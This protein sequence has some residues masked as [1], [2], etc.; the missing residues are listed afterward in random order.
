M[1][2]SSKSKPKHSIGRD[3]KLIGTGVAKELVLVGLY[4]IQELTGADLHYK[5]RKG[6]QP[7]EKRWGER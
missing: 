3:V 4:G 1:T 5:P 7:W 2:K 6:K